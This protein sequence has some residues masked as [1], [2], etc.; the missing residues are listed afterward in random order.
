[1][2]I[3]REASPPTPG[4]DDTPYIRFALDQLTRDEEV[5]GSRQY[6]GLGSGADSNYPYVPPEPLTAQRVVPVRG[7][8]EV[9]IDWPLQGQK[10]SVQQPQQLARPPA[11]QPNL[12]SEAKDVLQQPAIPPSAMWAQ[13]RQTEIQRDAYDEPPPRSPRRTTNS[14]STDGVYPLQSEP[15]S[16][17][18]LRHSHLSQAEQ[19]PEVD[20]FV[21]LSASEAHQERLRS[22]PGVLRP[23]SIGLFLLFLLV[24]IALLVLSAAWSLS[25]QGIED[26]LN[27]GDARYFVFQYLPTLLGIILFLWLVQIMV[28]VYRLAPFI[29]VSSS[30]SVRERGAR[31]PLYPKGFVLP[32]LG[33]FRAGLPIVGIFMVTAWLQIFT[34]PLLG[35]IFNVFFFGDSASG[36]WR[37]VATQAAIWVVIVLYVLLFLTVIVLLLW[38]RG[39]NTGLKWD[40]KTL[41]D[42]IVL[43]ER[44]NALDGVE[45]EEEPPQLGYWKTLKRS[46]VF[47]TYGV[48]DKAAR[49]YGVEDGRIREKTPV[50][51]QNRF[52]DNEHDAG[53]RD[54]REKM[55]PRP[56]EDE[57]EP[58]ARHYNA[59]PWF[60]RPS[61]ALLWII[62]ALVLLVA[63]LVVSYLPTTRVANGF[64]PAV[65]APVNSAGFSSTNFLYSFLPSLLGML[66]LLFWLDIDYAYRRLQPFTAL[67]H[68]EGALAEKSLLLSYVSDV[69]PAP[70]ALANGHWRIAILSTTT[71]FAAAL[72]VLAGGVFWAQFY[73]PSQS[74]RISADMPAY[75]ALT[76]FAA[77]YALSYLAIF[78]GARTRAACALLPNK[79]ASFAD[80]IALVHQSRVLDDIAFH[81]PRD[82]IDLVTRLLSAP[83][84]LRRLDEAAASKASLADSLRGFGKARQM[85]QNQ[86]L[87]PVQ[88]PRYYL[89]RYAGRNG[90]EFAGIDRLR[91]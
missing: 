21:P 59:L 55:I 42:V 24:L 79:A 11:W 70:T 36:H 5:R 13:Q 56:Q 10:E 89:G 82:R 37:W 80:L 46:Q 38:L 57:H 73:V 58:A 61:I 83:P 15:R 27:F 48:V 22:T 72:P 2:D 76:A 67:S 65:P 7:S 6:R 81:A 18:P 29:A 84:G 30:S 26:Y 20:T 75:Y 85:A 19:V 66:C 49:M 41:A 63:F 12:R 43:L 51:S 50:Q 31:L 74:I 88:V 14:G 39:R 53:I 25:H 23:L 45:V 4:M 60:L 32:F 16:N 69:F 68:S 90:R 52:S 33:H 9:P 17:R 78:P 35:S 47:H 8:H 77:L 34:I 64:S 91:T 3:D 28:A 86:G 44:S 71:F 1:M 87:G 40:P 62:V 54:S